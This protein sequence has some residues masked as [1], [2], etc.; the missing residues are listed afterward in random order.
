M[1]NDV[2][3]LLQAMVTTTTDLTLDHVDLVASTSGP[4]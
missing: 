4:S 1:T 3:S 2:C